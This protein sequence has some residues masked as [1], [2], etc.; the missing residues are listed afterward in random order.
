V[1]AN[2]YSSWR[3]LHPDLDRSQAG[4]AGLGLSPT[5]A[6]AMAKGDAAVRQA[7]L[8]LLSTSPGERVMRPTYGCD[9]RRLIFS[10]NDYTTAGL[11]RHYVRRAIERW[12][13]RVRILKLD[14]R[15]DPEVPTQLVIFLEYEVLASRRSDHLAFALNLTAEAA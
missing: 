10:P 12:E 8:L 14:A 15:P 2:T 4:Y 1:K 11:A 7:L 6:I 3:F 13:P 5:G 9:L